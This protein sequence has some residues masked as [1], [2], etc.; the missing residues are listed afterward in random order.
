MFR[1]FKE[2]IYLK[3]VNT[4]LQNLENHKVLLK[5]LVRINE[6]PCV[7]MDPVGAALVSLLFSQQD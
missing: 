2:C 7:V 4:A 5:D 3:K 1:G 6:I